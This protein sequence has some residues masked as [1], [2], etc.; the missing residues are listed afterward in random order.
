MNDHLKTKDNYDKNAKL[1]QKKF[2][3]IL[4]RTND[5][6]LA[7]S[8]IK[9]NN[10]K[11]LEIGCAYGR[12]AKEILKLTNNYIGIDYSK[13]MISLAKKEKIKTK[14]VVAD[15]LT[16]KFPKNRDIIFSFASLLHSNKEEM[17]IIFN[18]INKSLNKNGILFLSLKYGKYK[19][20]YLKDDYGIRVHYRYTPN[21]IKK[22][23]NNFLI[24]YKNVHILRGQ[25]WFEMIL[26]KK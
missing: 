12:D 1:Y 11:V 4:P 5:I 8:F 25:K 21:E 17:I 24:E 6:K 20:I 14:F 16:Y 23:A 3:S 19:K 7:F 10:P 18:K 2:E 15:A 26:R 13:S 9:K 22:L